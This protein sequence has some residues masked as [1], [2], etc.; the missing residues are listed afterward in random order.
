V[1]NDFFSLSDARLKPGKPM[2]KSYERIRAARNEGAM[3]RYGREVFDRALEAE[4][5]TAALFRA[6]AWGQPSH[7]D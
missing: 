2:R 6:V 7:Y 4:N 3:W 1:T 5:P